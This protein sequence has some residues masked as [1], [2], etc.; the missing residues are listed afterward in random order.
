MTMNA[1]VD[2]MRTVPLRRASTL[3]VRSDIIPIKGLKMGCTPTES[4]LASTLECFY[5]VSC[6]NLIQ[7]HVTP[8]NGANTTDA[9]PLFANSSRF[10][11]KTLMIDLVKDLFVET[12]SNNTNY[13]AY[14][15]L[16][17]PTSCSYTYVQQL[18]SLYTVTVILGLYGGLNVVLQGICRILIYL[19]FKVYRYI[20]KRSNLVDAEHSSEMATIEGANATHTATSLKSVPTGGTAK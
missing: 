8:M 9:S 11:P 5:D 14:F 15:T 3:Q 1:P 6:I 13:S 10:P 19:L 12:W 16:C 7:E 18:N 2:C 17:S 20:R 4:F